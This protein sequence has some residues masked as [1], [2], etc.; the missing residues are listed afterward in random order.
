[1][2]RFSTGKALLWALLAL[3]ALPILYRA[4]AEADL[5][6]EDLLHPTGEWSARLIVLAL[7]LTP[8]SML[9]PGRRW[10]Q[11]LVRHRRAFGVAAFAYAALHLAVYV[12]AMEELRAMLA[13]I[14]APSIWTAWLAFLFLVPVAITSNDAAM[15][16]LKA[17]WKRIQRLAYPAA[18][19]TLAHWL[20]VHDGLSEAL[21]T[22][23]PLI[24][25]QTFRLAR[26]A[27]PR[28]FTPRR[29]T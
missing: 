8:L 4:A 11:W 17:G 20:L 15:R 28:F 10:V 26:V 22:F 21:L 2:T 29:M 27:G 16:R 18:I 6:W 12:V 7:M 23:S 1:V 24:A 5:W 9:L 19:L 13:E 25:L 3:P 14:G